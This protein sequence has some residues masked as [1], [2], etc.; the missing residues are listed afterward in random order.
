[1]ILFLPA[2]FIAIFNI[3]LNNNALGGSLTMLAVI[4]AIGSIGLFTWRIFTP[5]GGILSYF[6]AENSKTLFA[7]L[8]PVWVSALMLYIAGLIILVRAGYL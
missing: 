8:R 2:A 7:Q 1:M 4:F 3:Q 6:L 5:R